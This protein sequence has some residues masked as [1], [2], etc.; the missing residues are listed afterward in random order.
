MLKDTNR[1]DALLRELEL[2]EWVERIRTKL[3][4]DH[5]GEQ[6]VEV[7]F[8]V[9]AGNESIFYDGDMLSSISIRV[10]RLLQ[11]HDIELWPYVHFVDTREAA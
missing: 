5:V 10:L 8:V 7:W 1:I 9:R 11:A 6:A 4:F 2:P 3:I